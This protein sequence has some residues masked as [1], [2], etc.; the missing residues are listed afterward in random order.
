MISRA[1]YDEW[2]EA[3]DGKVKAL[4]LIGQTRDKI[5]ACAKKHG[6]ENIILADTFEEAFEVLQT[7]GR[8][9]E[10]LCCCPLPAQAGVCSRIMR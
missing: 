5:A 6:V 3:F 1:T 8:S 10:M 4:V 7:T 9:R 2:I